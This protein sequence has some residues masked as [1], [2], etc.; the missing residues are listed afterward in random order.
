MSQD[1]IELSEFLREHLRKD[2]IILLGHSWGSIL[3]IHIVKKRPDLVYAY[4]GTGQVAN[5]QKSIAIGY[6]YLLERAERAAR[7]AVSL[8]VDRQDALRVRCARAGRGLLQ[9]V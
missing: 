1:G 8:R 3:G 5:M 9:P 7:R 4:V 6:A 2:K